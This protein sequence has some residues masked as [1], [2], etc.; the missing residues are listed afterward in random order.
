M[1]SNL[2]AFLDMIAWC[3]GTSTSKY[4]KN[5]GYDVIVGGIDSPNIFTDYSN[6]PNVL[7]TVNNKGLKSTAAGR[8]QLLSRYYKAYKELL[9]LSDFSPASQDAI[10]IQQIKERKALDDIVNGDIE[11]AISKVNNIWASLPNSK[12]GQ[13]TRTINACI[14]KYKEFG[15]TVNA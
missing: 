14:A 9:N 4:T 10:A 1:N 11:R 12:Y 13:P 2:K 8:Y 7:V 6:H 15:G 3:E 5:N